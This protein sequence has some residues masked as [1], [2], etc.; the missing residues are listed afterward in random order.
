VTSYFLRR[1]LLIVPTF[2]GI[3]MAVFVI[4]HFVPGGPVE[5]QI[6]RYKMAAMTEGGAVGGGRMMSL[7]EDAVEE[8]RRYYG[9]DKPVHVRYIEWLGNVVQ[10]DLGNS[11]IY[12][13]PVWDVIKARFP[14]SLFLGLTGFLLNYLI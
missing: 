6:M 1:L 5:R 13:E 3:T 12:Q 4:M 11:Y 2:I 9:F 7:P 8:I 14:I 10:L